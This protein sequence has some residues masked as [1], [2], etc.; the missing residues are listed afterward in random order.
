MAKLEVILSIY[1]YISTIYLVQ[2]VIAKL[3][4]FYVKYLS[5]IDGVLAYLSVTYE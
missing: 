4:K 2:K 1:V 3:A 5:L